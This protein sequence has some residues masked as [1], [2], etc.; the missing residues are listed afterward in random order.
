MKQPGGQPEG[1]PTR[2]SEN[3][4]ILKGI[5]KETK[6]FEAAGRPAGRNA[7]H[8]DSKKYAANATDGSEDAT[9]AAPIP[10]K[11]RPLVPTLAR[12]GRNTARYKRSSNSR[13]SAVAGPDN[14]EDRA[15][16]RTLQAQL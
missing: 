14:G 4:H 1:P 8:T 12:T 6:L 7:P 15:E 16:H 3:E 9:S 5:N 10:K 2:E 13:K 11:A